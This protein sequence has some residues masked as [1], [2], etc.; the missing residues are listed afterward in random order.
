MKSGERSET[1]VAVSPAR[2]TY[3]KHES[4]GRHLEWTTGSR[5]R[6]AALSPPE[7]QRAS[8]GLLAAA[9]SP[10]SGQGETA[11]LE[12]GSTFRPRRSCSCAAGAMQHRSNGHIVGDL[13]ARRGHGQRGLL[14]LCNEHSGA[15]DERPAKRGI[16]ARCG[17]SHSC[18]HVNLKAR[19]HWQH[20]D[21]A[22]PVPALGIAVSDR[23]SV[24]TAGGE[25][26]WAPEGVSSPR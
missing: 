2:T 5:H 19:L 10:R 20:S 24:S 22:D 4:C 8:F 23:P 21:R 26:P 11:G 18:S 1:Q 3:L 9:S 7:H 16:Q 25:R 14:S 6:D 13:G 12:R 15:A 17:R